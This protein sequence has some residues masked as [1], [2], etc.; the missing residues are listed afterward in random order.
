MEYSNTIGCRLL[1]LREQK[2]LTQLKAAKA[3]GVG[4][5]EVISQYENNKTKPNI[6]KL[7]KLADLYGVSCDYILRGVSAENLDVFKST[8]MIDSSISI[9]RD[10]NIAWNKAEIIRA[11]KKFQSNTQDTQKNKV[12]LTD[13]IPY[14]NYID[15]LNAIIC[16]GTSSSLHPEMRKGSGFFHII[17][18]VWLAA[19]YMLKHE[20]GTLTLNE[21][22][23]SDM[24]NRGLIILK[25]DEAAKYELKKAKEDMSI[26]LDNVL[27]TLVESRKEKKVL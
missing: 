10:I 27:K 22:Q 16:D 20:N 3:I 13:G 19:C 8:G 6:D 12:Q 23:M 1:E 7:I 24:H 14:P 5:R 18:E 26:I 21:A 15:V 4:K 11:T 25:P 17:K 9:I 2:G